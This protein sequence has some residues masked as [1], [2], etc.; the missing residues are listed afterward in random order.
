MAILKNFTRQETKVKDLFNYASLSIMGLGKNTGKTMFLN[1]LVDLKETSFP[2]R[3]LAIT[4]IG[5]DGEERDVVTKGK[6]P[7]IYIPE[8]TLVAT[9]K[10][11]LSRCD[12]TKEILKTTG[13]YS[14]MGEVVLFRSLSDGYVE[15]A[16]PS[17][18]GDLKT[19]EQMIRQVSPE[20]L[21]L[22]DGAL[23]RMSFSTET[24]A[25]VLCTG[26]NLHKDLVKVQEKTL[27]AL[28]C[29]K[30]PKSPVDSPKGNH[31]VYVHQGHW[32]EVE[33][34]EAH[35]MDALGPMLE[36]S[37][38]GIYIRGAVTES[39]VDKLLTKKNFR[40][41]FLVGKDGTKF[42]LG[43]EMTLRLK[44]RNITLFV[45]NPLYVPMILVNPYDLQGL[46][47]P[48]DTLTKRL[49]EETKM[50]VFVLDDLGRSGDY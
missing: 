31:R 7:R 25:S 47:V 49:E 28:Y 44:R 30:L 39:L 37:V 40:D 1:A 26:V 4:S 13:I 27:H 11:L 5:R 29:L 2:E 41:L 35:L 48:V 33:V 16:G 23:S 46:K 34:N 10:G 6:K 32:K 21:F 50:P 20:A 8:G 12:V 17:R 3:I 38:E 42:L 22:V 43:E 9:S 45:E 14:A 15:I 24:E 36:D 18:S 19:L